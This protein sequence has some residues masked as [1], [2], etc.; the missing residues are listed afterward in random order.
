VK[1]FICD[2]IKVKFFIPGRI[3]LNINLLYKNKA[4]SQK[5]LQT[6]NNKNN[7]LSVHVNIS[8]SEL[9]IIYDYK[10]LSESDLKYLIETELRPLTETD[11]NKLNL[12]KTNHS[13]RVKNSIYENEKGISRRIA[14]TSAIVI[15][16]ISMTSFN[17]ST[18][19]STM[20]LSSPFILFYIRKKV[21]NL[22]SSL[23]LEK[24][25]S[26]QKCSL[27]KFFSEVDEIY[28]QDDLVIDKSIVKNNT[29][30]INNNR[31]SI[32]RLVI[33][34]ELEDP[35][36]VASKLLIKNFRNIGINKIFLL[37]KQTNKFTK[38][39]SDVLGI[40][41]LTLNEGYMTAHINNFS[42]QPLIIILGTN[43]HN[44]GTHNSLDIFVYEEFDEE[45][46]ED[47]HL[48]SLCKRDI[49][50]LPKAILLC[51]YMENTINTTENISVAINMIGIIL[52][53]SRCISIPAS[54]MIYLLN[55][56]FSRIL[57]K[58]GL[59]DNNLTVVKSLK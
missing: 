46:L 13:N 39:A 49:L 6:I 44:N 21:Y 23:L 5:I 43:K 3:R 58:K 55:F 57:L 45:K 27:I 4:L 8:N 52:A 11:F 50:E 47:K 36:F 54:I 51:K 56:G 34:K 28:L 37:S 25:V 48:A 2:K 1:D 33:Y 10:Q 59:R 38:Y 26:L 29:D 15:G 24:K 41:S 20:I 30:F 16:T 31:Y 17:V 53:I 12:I 7:I 19:V 18:I 35:I 42:E 9:L 40:N 22:T 14:L 32:E